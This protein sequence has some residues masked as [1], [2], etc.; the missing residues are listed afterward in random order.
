MRF[1][2][3]DGDDTPVGRLLSR[4]EAVALLGVSG[5]ALLAGCDRISVS[6][7]RDLPPG[8][9]ATATGSSA[10]PS[11][12][13]RPQQTE[14]P[15]FVDENLRRNDIRSD[16]ATGEV[17]PGAPLQLALAA[18]LVTDGGC[19]PLSGAH[20]DLW[21][22]D[23]L[24]VYSDVVDPGFNTVGQKFLRGYQLTDQEGRV[25]F[26]TIY[27]GWYPGR[28]VH[29]H[30][31]VR[32]DP[33]AAQGYEF[34]SQLYFDDSLTDRV[35][36]REPY[37]RK[38]QRTRRNRDDGIFQNGGEQLMLALTGDE[39]GYVAQFHIGIH[40]YQRRGNPRVRGIL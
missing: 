5:A 11:C 16:P 25:R 9:A 22:C 35:H 36:A 38:G 6:V 14:G 24:G 1:D 21:Q 39:Q 37:A 28:T 2:R 7:E 33:A 31:K 30:F 15:Y 34:T 3:G 27:P 26:T 32:T 4:R 17:R 8:E 10:V 18:S 23:A 12:V 19:T 40:P 20:V 13:V 29:L